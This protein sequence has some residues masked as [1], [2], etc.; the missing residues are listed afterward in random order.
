KVWSRKWL[1][2][3]L[4]C[5]R[6]A[7]IKFRRTCWPA[8]GVTQIDND[9][10]SRASAYNNLK[11]NLQNLERKNA[12]SLLTRSLAEIVKKDDFVLDSEYLVTLLVVVPKLNHNDWIKQYETLAEM[13]VPRSSNV[14][15]EDQDSYL[16]NVTLFRK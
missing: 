9:L 16:C 1:S 3:W 11:G 10:K 8:E 6:T 2:T 14:L 15:S 5:W 12:G 4:M 13:V 7:K